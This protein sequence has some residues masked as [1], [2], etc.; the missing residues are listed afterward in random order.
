MTTHDSGRPERG[1]PQ[2]ADKA[3]VNTGSSIATTADMQ[4]NLHT[5]H[6]LVNTLAAQRA[7]VERVRDEAWRDGFTAG[8]DAGH[9]VGYGAA[10]HEMNVV[11]A[12]VARRVRALGSPT[13]Q[14]Y[15]E[16]R[17]AELDACRPR[18]G[19]F[20]GLERDPHCLDRPRAANRTETAAA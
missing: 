17:A 18:A 2:T 4:R 1:R 15:S 16:R 8:F 6:E 14:T 12:E 13:S 3:D 10:E 7:E 9:D 11:W 20:P 5:A 19:D